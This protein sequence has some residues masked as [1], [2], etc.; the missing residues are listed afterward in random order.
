MG[1]RRLLIWGLLGTCSLMV[2]LVTWSLYGVMGE[3]RRQEEEA[4]SRVGALGDASRQEL[5]KRDFQ[6]LGNGTMEVLSPN[7]D[8]LGL[9]FPKQVAVLFGKR[10]LWAV[11][12]FAPPAADIPEK[13]TSLVVKAGLGQWVY[14]ATLEDG[15]TFLASF[16]GPSYA[17]AEARA[18]T[19]A[20]FEVAAAGALIL[21]WG[22]L[23]W[24]LYTSYQTVVAAIR[25]TDGLI[26]A[27]SQG[28]IAP[29]DVLAIFQR[30]VAELRQRTQELEK[31]HQAERR[32]A[33]DVES[34]VKALCENLDAG[35]LRFDPE[36]RLAQANADGRRLLG[37]PT[38]PMLGESAE[39]TFAPLPEIGALPPEAVR[40]RSVVIRDEVPG[41]DGRLLQV[42]AIPLYSQTNSSQGALLVLR[43]M[44]SYYRMARDLRETEALSR[45]GEVAA[46]VAHEVRNGLSVLTLQLKLLRED[47][48]ELAEEARLKLVEQEISQLAKVASDLLFYAR[49]LKLEKEPVEVA[50]IL[51]TIANTLKGLFPGLSVSVEAEAGLLADCDSEALS[52]ALLNL[53]Q[54]GAEAARQAHP[55][56]GRVILRAGAEE[57][58]CTRIVVED[59]GAGIPQSVREN[60]F[61]PFVTE[62]PGGTGLGLP[63]ARKIAREHGGDLLP[64][65]PA[66]LPGAAFELAL[67]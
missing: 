13:G 26:T 30:T 49:P 19:A 56:G 55:G 23:A 4:R 32:R 63:I 17:R 35:Y 62:K 36:G 60:L 43:D 47:H 39:R 58:N 50:A 10:V 12:P 65:A 31:L 52:R 14:A 67:P 5:A 64:C 25:Q 22:L 8:A 33:Q 7:R 61:A 2:L 53:G 44:T 15:R 18:R 3:M 28:E 24:R 20:A 54:N 27:R 40:T 57:E 51:E 6:Q 42:A 45:L 11:P 16:D 29:Q 1:L 48:S 21:F 66:S 37:L 46:G 38:V 9:L 59:D 34:M 41:A